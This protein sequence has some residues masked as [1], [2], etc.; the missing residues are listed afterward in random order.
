MSLLRLVKSVNALS[1]S[2][3]PPR[4]CLVRA[5]STQAAAESAPVNLILAEEKEMRAPRIVYTAEQ[6]TLRPAAF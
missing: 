5:A 3:A 1:L 6:G 4:S 2:A